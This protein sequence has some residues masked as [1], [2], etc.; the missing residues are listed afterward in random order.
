MQVGL[1][2]IGLFALAA[3]LVLL[4]GRGGFW[5]ARERL[6]QDG[7]ELAAWPA[8]V[9][10]VPARDEAA[11]IERTA[12][13]LLAQ[14]YPGPFSVILVDDH[15]S[16]GTARLARRAA[17]SCGRSGRLTV[18]EARPLPPG[19]TGKLWALAEGLRRGEAEA[20][21]AGYVL[22]TDADILHDPGSLAR[23]VAKAERE[24]RDLVSLMVL[25]RCDSPWERLLV[26]PFVFFFAMLYPFAWVGDPQARTAAAAG[27]C[28]LVRRAALARAGG[29]APIRG[30]II[31]DCALARLIKRDGRAG[32]PG[33]IWLGL[34]HRVTSIRPYESLASLW[35]MVSRSAFAQLG[36]SAGLL[37]ATL[38][39][40]AAVFLAPAGL[41]LAYPWHGSGLAAGLGAAAWALMAVTLAPILRLYGQP[42][43]MALLL[44][45]AAALY[46][47]MTLSSAIQHWRGRGGRW[48]G[49]VEAGRAGPGAR[50]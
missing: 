49:R 14:D 36:Y 28:M 24:D 47:A 23:L 19:W 2:L 7:P 15:S 29:L 41:A 37:A 34:T 20:P 45:A 8:V 38:A 27:G 50:P 44:P 3:W 31:D 30:E 5:R 11:V 10:V 42:R 21:Q 46:C 22:F 39:G 26:P 25:L 6:D 48:K 18:A 40:M 33:R 17:E 16:D 12:A 1:V 13:A 9:A 35:A 43:A 4:A 32:G